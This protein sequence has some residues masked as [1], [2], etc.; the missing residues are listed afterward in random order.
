MKPAARQYVAENVQKLCKYPGCENHRFSM[1]SY[2]KAHRYEANKRRLYGWTGGRRVQKQ[3]LAPYKKECQDLIKRNISHEAIKSSIQFLDNWLLSAAQG[4]NVKLPDEMAALYERGI[5]GADLLATC[6]SVIR[7]S[8]KHPNI[9][10]PERLTW[11]LAVGRAVLQSIPCGRLKLTP[12]R[13]AG[14]KVLNDIGGILLK[15]HTGID[16]YAE[17][18]AEKKA[19][20]A[21]EFEWEG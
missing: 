12:I 2:C 13:I 9:L 19:K 5:R 7:F 21:L 8:Y 1:G 16:K 15:I 10:P 17:Q 4:L 11:T 3:E 18:Q 14:N 20:I 6:A